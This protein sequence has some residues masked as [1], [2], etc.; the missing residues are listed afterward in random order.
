MTENET[1]QLK[2]YNLALKYLGMNKISS[3]T[4]TDPSTVACNDHFID[5]RDDVFSEHQWSFANV[6][7]TLNP[8]SV[9]APLGWEFAYDYPT[10]NC[11]AVWMVYN[12]ATVDQKHEQD[13][14]VLYDP[15]TDGKLICSNL[16]DAYYEYTYIV[17][18]ISMWSKKFVIAVAH[19][20]AAEICPFLVGDDKK[21]L[22]EMQI[23]SAIISEAKR[24]DG[25]EQKKKPIQSCAAQDVR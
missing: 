15:T 8:S 24:V 20:L 11:A 10:E 21:S 5:C 12:E 13:F 2:I 6:Q 1:L 19:R 3:L 4:G 22:N 14:Q 18:N 7:A 16:D 23:Y 25:I 9:E 17:E